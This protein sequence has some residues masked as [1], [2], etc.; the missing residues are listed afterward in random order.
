MLS[1]ALAWTGTK[2]SRENCRGLLCHELRLGTKVVAQRVKCEMRQNGGRTEMRGNEFQFSDEER[3]EPSPM[4][5][6]GEG[7]KRKT[8]GEGS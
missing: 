7:L 3:E 2:A 6:K 8:S 5:E 1:A 4:K